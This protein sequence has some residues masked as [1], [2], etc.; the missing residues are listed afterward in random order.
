M[1]KTVA[2]NTEMAVETYKELQA[3]IH[4]TGVSIKSLATAYKVKALDE[5]T[6]TQAKEAIERLK[7]KPTKN[8]GAE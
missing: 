2:N 1:G 3:E 4:R 7:A 5:L 8:A 6:E